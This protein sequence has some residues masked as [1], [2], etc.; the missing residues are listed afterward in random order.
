MFYSSSVAIRSR[1]GGGPGRSV[2]L[3]E[4]SDLTSGQLRFR[5]S[6]LRSSIHFAPL[7][8]RSALPPHCSRQCKRKAKVRLWTFFGGMEPKGSLGT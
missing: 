1:P 5:D 7:T 2:R 4:T 8:K 3:A 6:L